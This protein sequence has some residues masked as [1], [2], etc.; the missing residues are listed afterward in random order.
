MRQSQT[1]T[2]GRVQ[3]D[4]DKTRPLVSPLSVVAPGQMGGRGWPGNY[5]ST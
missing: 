2:G 5:S 1:V 4:G 3:W